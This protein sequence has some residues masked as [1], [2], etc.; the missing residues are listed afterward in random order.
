[1]A[2]SSVPKERS[3]RKRMHLAL[4]EAEERYKHKLLGSEERLVLRDRIIKLKTRLA[5]LAASS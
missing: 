2:T 4:R 1:M 5:K 3:A